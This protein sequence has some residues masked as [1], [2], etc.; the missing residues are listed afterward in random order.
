MKKTKSEETKHKET[1]REAT[2]SEETKHRETKRE[3]FRWRN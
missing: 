2:K 3:V 1:K